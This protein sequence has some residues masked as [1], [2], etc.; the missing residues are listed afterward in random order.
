MTRAE[1]LS[2]LSE[3]LSVL[4]EV[5][6]REAVS[7]YENIFL[8]G[9]SDTAVMLRLGN[10]YILAK[11]I[12]SEQSEWN[13]TPQYQN[14]KRDGMTPVTFAEPPESYPQREEA[15]IKTAEQGTEYRAPSAEYRGRKRIKHPL[16]LLLSIL[17][18]I[19][20]LT[21]GVIGA[22]VL[23]HDI[24]TWNSQPNQYIAATEMFAVPEMISP[25][26][27][28]TDSLLPDNVLY[29]ILPEKKN[30]TGSSWQS[31][32]GS[33]NT[34][35]M[36]LFE[37]DVTIRPGDFSIE[38]SANLDYSFTNGVLTVE[39][40]DPGG[41][42][43]LYVPKYVKTLN[44]KMF[45][46]NIYCTDTVIAETVLELTDTEVTMDSM[47]FSDRLDYTATS[48]GHT[49]NNSSFGD[50]NIFNLTSA[51]ISS[52]NGLLSGGMYLNM[53]AGSGYWNFDGNSY[54]YQ[55]LN[56]AQAENAVQT[57]R[58]IVVDTEGV[59][60][61]DLSIVFMANE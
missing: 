7:Y 60:R 44:L 58:K 39:S 61:D 13:E 29:S 51:Y 4:P 9:T 54:E 22:A 5:T 57:P 53:I 37:T 10:P 47:T 27:P 50:E 59:T 36:E 34:V 46:G 35:N 30:E 23:A 21:I 26:D 1:F 6:R 2:E 56:K 32:S 40:S 33:L 31:L 38:Y 52:D 18:G 45:G 42:L 11:R 48:G 19:P 17:V 20:V 8:S 49:F 43:T 12:I 16:L 15:V 3:H 28:V 41:S 25:P 55:I 24:G 14:L